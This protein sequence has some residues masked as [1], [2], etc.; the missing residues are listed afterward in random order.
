MRIK[1]SMQT[2]IAPVHTYSG[3]RPRA[4]IVTKIAARTCDARSSGMTGLVGCRVAACSADRDW[5]GRGAAL[6]STGT[7]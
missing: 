6:P 1:Y 7:H 3:N 4:D 2:D 5:F